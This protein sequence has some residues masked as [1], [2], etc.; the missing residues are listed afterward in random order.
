MIHC[1]WE[2]VIGE[3]TLK[4]PSKAQHSIH[5]LSTQPHKDSKNRIMYALSQPREQGPCPSPSAPP[6]RC[7]LCLVLAG[8]G[9]DIGDYC[10]GLYRVW[11]IRRPSGVLDESEVKPPFFPPF[12]APKKRA[13]ESPQGGGGAT[14]FVFHG[15]RRACTKRR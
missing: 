1:I 11:F 7:L 12:T 15:G 10:W 14:H 5:T 13:R 3:K 4:T 8:N 9:G 6:S 2:F